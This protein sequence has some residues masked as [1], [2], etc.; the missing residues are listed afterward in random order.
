MEVY[1][2]SAQFVCVRKEKNGLIIL[3]DPIEVDVNCLPFFFSKYPS[4]KGTNSNPNF[5]EKKCFWQECVV[6]KLQNLK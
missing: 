3:D 4:I 6:R 1:N 2:L 5:R